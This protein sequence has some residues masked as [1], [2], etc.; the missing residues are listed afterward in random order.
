[1]LLGGSGRRHRAR[2]VLTG[3]GL[4]LGQLLVRRYTAEA[5]PVQSGV[6]A[7]LAVRED[8]GAASTEIDIALAAERGLRFLLRELGIRD[9]VHLPAREARGE[10]GV[11]PF[12]ADRERELVVG[13]DPG[14]IA[15]IVVDVDLAHTRGRE[16]LRDEARRLGVPRDD[17]DL[18]AAA[19]GDDHARLE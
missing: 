7:A 15:G 1:A 11:Q 12:L 6:G 3:L 17:V 8:R 10:A 16:R 9:D 4:D 13:D 18:L 5:G 2:G 14:G 19:L